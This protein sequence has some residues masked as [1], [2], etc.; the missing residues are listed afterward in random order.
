MPA[1]MKPISDLEIFVPSNSF[2]K[3]MIPL[4][5]YRKGIDENSLFLYTHYV[6]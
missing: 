6:I 2:H 5:I 4:S 3:S 1:G